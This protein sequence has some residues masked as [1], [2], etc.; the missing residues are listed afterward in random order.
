MSKIGRKK[1]WKS[2]GA[3]RG[4]SRGLQDL[5][6]G[7]SALERLYMYIYSISRISMRVPNVLCISTPLRHA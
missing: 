2:I 6:C 3:K 5:A 4:Q 7:V 1:L